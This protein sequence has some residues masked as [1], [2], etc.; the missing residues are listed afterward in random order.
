MVTDVFLHKCSAWEQLDSKGYGK[1]TYS[2]LSC[3]VTNQ[4]CVVTSTVL[5]LDL[6]ALVQIGTEHY[7]F[8]LVS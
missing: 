1:A 8:Q 5:C 6:T 4:C 2:S 3:V 7:I